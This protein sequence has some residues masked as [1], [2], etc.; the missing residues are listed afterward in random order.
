MTVKLQLDGIEVSIDF[1]EVDENNFQLYIRHDEKF[2]SS[3]SDTGQ[4][5]LKRINIRK[6]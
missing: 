3:S 2:S 6:M 5:S 1:I 4:N